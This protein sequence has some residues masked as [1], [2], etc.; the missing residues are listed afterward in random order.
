[1]QLALADMLDEI[2]ANGTIGDTEC[3]SSSVSRRSRR[4]KGRQEIQSSVPNGAETTSRSLT[5]DAGAVIAMHLTVK[6]H[7]TGAISPGE[8]A[9]SLHDDL[10]R[11]VSDGSFEAS[12][13]S[14]ATKRG[15][16][17]LNKFTVAGTHVSTHTPTMAPSVAL[18]PSPNPKSLAPSIKAP[19]LASST[20]PTQH[21]E[22]DG[23]L[24]SAE[25]MVSKVRLIELVASAGFVLLLCCCCIWRCCRKRR[26]K[27]KA[28]R[29]SSKSKSAKD[30]MKVV[31]VSPSS[32]KAMTA[33]DRKSQ[34][35]PFAV[36]TEVYPAGRRK[37]S[38]RSSGNSTVQSFDS[39]DSDSGSDSDSSSSGG[40]SGSSGS[41]SDSENGVRNGD[42]S[43]LDVEE[44]D[45]SMIRSARLTFESI[46]DTRHIVDWRQQR[47]NG[48]QRRM[49]DR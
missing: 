39:S 6:S 35:A 19:S 9:N 23:V 49:S 41:N 25:E 2:G 43:L 5:D 31:V 40:S 33:S 44:D 11:S 46:E 26:P 14:V 30:D 28:K 17:T 13:Q 22:S 29:R 18:D 45:N 4:L 12:I 27:K 8:L 21:P 3:S 36:A 34:V 48:N 16:S 24:A 15:V 20:A 10:G 47:R 32:V 37:S 42:L 7:L 38:R 1:M